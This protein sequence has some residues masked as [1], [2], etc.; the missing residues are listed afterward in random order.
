MKYT[1][2]V[3]DFNGTVL[4]DV[5][6]GI[7]AVNCLLAERGLPTLKDAE[8]YRRV[9]HFPIKHYY[10]ALGFD[11]EKESYEALAPQWV[12]LYL[13]MVPDAPLCKGA[14]EVLSSFRAHGLSQT[15]LSATERGMLQGQVKGLG[16]ADYFDEILGL[17]HI[18]ANSKIAIAHAWRE[19]HP[20]AHA[21]MIG[22]TE[23]DFESAEAMQMDC[24][25]IA[26]G[27]QPKETLAAT[28]ARVFDSLLDLLAYLMAENLI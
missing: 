5:D 22:D 20:D 24:Y 26:G 10:Q 16:V 14:L 12:S 27:H 1:H 7:R 13:Q 6:T 3:W 4:D 15:L 8:A 28:G 18:H 19:A 11:F 9:F 25:L 23:H 21:F 17:D 2:A